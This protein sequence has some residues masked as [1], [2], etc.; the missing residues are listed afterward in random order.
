MLTSNDF[1]RLGILND[2][3]EVKVPKNKLAKLMYYLDCV[4]SI[5]DCPG[6]DFYSINIYK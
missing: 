1:M 2:G 5:L 6:Y 3:D 4:F